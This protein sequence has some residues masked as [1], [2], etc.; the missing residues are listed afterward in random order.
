MIE[1]MVI[2]C[3]FVCD[4]KLHKRVLS[5]VSI[6]PS[7][8]GVA[9]CEVLNRCLT[10]W[11]VAHKFATVTVDNATYSDVAIRK[12]KDVLSYQ[13]KLPFDGKLFHV[14][15]C[16]HI[17]N[18]LVKC[19]LDEIE[20]IIHNVRETVKHI[21]A[22]K[23]RLKL[24]SEVVKSWQLS[25]KKLVLDCPTRWNSTYDMLS[26]ALEFKD[27]FKYYEEKDTSYKNCPMK[28]DWVKVEKGC[29]FL[30][31]SKRSQR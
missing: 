29:S 9:V 11:N 17:L 16:A 24:F 7:H 18:I 28:D 26:L 31:I 23:L 19:G 25:G 10:D 13:K 4:W 5:F 27:V 12:L 8:S 6:P 30:E 15:Y 20:V 2:T 22:S 1:Y 3:H 21:S 14:C